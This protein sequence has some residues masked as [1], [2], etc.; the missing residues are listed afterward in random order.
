[1]APAA[2]A[3]PASDRAFL[4]HPR[5]L[6]VLAFSEA[7]ERFSYSGMQTLL[8]L[9]T[10]HS[11]FQPENIGKIW[12]FAGFRGALEALYG[13][14]STA[15]LAS[16]TFGIYAGLVYLTPI[17][18]GLLADRLLGKTRTVIIGAVLLTA[19]HWLMAYEQSFLI[20]LAC[21][22]L[23]VGCFKTNITG[24]VGDLYVLG[25][26]RRA[27]AFQ[28]FV[29]FIAI[30]AVAAPLVCGTLGEKVSWSWG[31]GSAGIGMVVGLFTYL[32]GRRWLPPEPAPKKRGGVVE[33]RPRLAPGEGR[34]ILI[35]VLLLPVLT[36][37][38]V[39]NEQM[40]NAYLLWGEANYQLT[41]FG[42]TMPITWLISIDS[43]IAILAMSGSL[44][45]WR[46]WGKRRHEPDEITKLTIG[47]MICALAPLVLSV[48]SL[49]AAGGHRVSLGW[50]LVF[51]AINEVGFANVYPVGMAL[52]SRCAPRALGG[53]MIA[54]YFLHLFA[55]NVLVGRLG[56][57]LSTMSGASFWLLHAGLIAVAALILLLVRKLA[58][59]LLAPTVD[60]EAAFA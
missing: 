55:A 52:Y 13:P 38:T 1:M 2:V 45:F 24:Q 50:G 8:V 18:G 33:P 5:G 56:G 3:S 28:I 10:A 19:G 46:W 36:L 21:L 14:L 49:Y 9:Y 47:T 58:G 59:R 54:I 20:A 44:L 11:L 43:V 40:F 53:T 22:V 27:R 15:A 17:L 32:G 34:V 6:A 16:S 51:H 30:A 35:L 31:F 37:S 57:L 25:D 41:F 29:L 42:M 60:P 12:G 26:P 4:G 7:W 39:G 48:A 23:G